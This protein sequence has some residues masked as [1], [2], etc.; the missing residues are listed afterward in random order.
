[1]FQKATKENVYLKIALVGSPGAGKTYSALAI[2]AQFTD[3]IAVIDTE[4]GSS[5]LYADQFSFDMCELTNHQPIKYVEAINAAIGAGYQAIIIDSLSHAWFAELEMI[6]GKNTFTAWAKVRPQERTL[7]E[8]IISAKAHVIVTMREKTEWDTSQTDEYGKMK[9]VKVGMKAVQ[10]SGIEYEFDIVGRLNQEHVLAITKTRCPAIANHAFIHPG[11]QLAT[12]LKVWLGL[13]KPAQA[14]S[15]IPT[16]PDIT[17][18]EANERI[19]RELKRIGWST[20]DAQMYLK[21]VYNKS[22]RSL[23]DDDQLLSFLTHLQS[24]PSHTGSI[25]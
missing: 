3:K 5:R 6:Q 22:S 16:L 2:A 1:M 8:T 11:R 9:P 20:S 10:S 14:P 4:R 18:S 25:N 17:P 23:L 13:E 7:I 15:L 24:L 21:K 12:E 19:M